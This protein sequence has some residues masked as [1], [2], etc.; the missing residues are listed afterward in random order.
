M[1]RLTVVLVAVCVV[2]STCDVTLADPNNPV[3]TPVGVTG[4]ADT[5]SSFT[6]P[7][8]AVENLI[9]G[10]ADPNG[11]NNGLIEDG[12][13]SPEVPVAIVT[14]QDALDA[15]HRNI[16][17]GEDPG[18]AAW[19]WVSAGRNGDDFSDFF[20]PSLNGDPITLD[21]DLGGTFDVSGMFIW[22]YNGGFGSIEQNNPKD[23]TISF[24]TDGGSN[25]GNTETISSLTNTGVGGQSVASEL[26]TFPS[27]Q[28]DFVRLTIT[29]NFK[30]E[31]GLAFG[32]D[33]V[34]LAE[35]R[36]QGSAVSVEDADFDE[37]GLVD[38]FDFLIWQQNEGSVGSGTLA[39]GDANGDMNVDADDLAIWETQ[40]GAASLS[41][42]VA[43]VPEP[44]G[45][46][47]SA[48]ALMFLLQTK[49]RRNQ[50]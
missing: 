33:R 32:G 48:L 9:N 13:V 20:D 3:I 47:L 37:S 14:V 18:L 50:Q 17:T 25:Y 15:E 34:G 39:N 5:A 22:R 19:H 16:F 29:D 46:A 11:T 23:W 1:F 49:H 6:F 12:T 43:S 35:V 45:I 4:S 8:G 10:N 24:S 42:S 38:G 2:V 31:P 28:A 41:S 40:Y 26:L 27:H 7:F 30:G 44:S 21:F 36:F